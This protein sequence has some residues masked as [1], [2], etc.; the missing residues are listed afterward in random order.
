MYSPESL[1]LAFDLLAQPRVQRP[2]YDGGTAR[3][4]PGLGAWLL[5]TDSHGQPWRICW[6]YNGIGFREL[7][8]V[9]SDRAP[10][11]LPVKELPGAWWPF[12]VRANTFLSERPGHEA[13]DE[14]EDATMPAAAAPSSW[15]CP[16]WCELPNGHGWQ[17]SGHTVVRAHRGTHRF[18][19]GDRHIVLVISVDEHATEHGIRWDAVDVRFAEVETPGPSETA[20]IHALLPQL[21]TLL[22]VA[23]LPLPPR[24]RLVGDLRVVDVPAALSTPAGRA[25]NRA[26]AAKLSRHRSTGNGAEEVA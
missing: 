21:G 15:V 11:M 7:T 3:T 6:Q 16:L 24:I 18:R 13:T 19:F 2:C 26:C 5:V 22:R 17:R 23:E 10:R 1:W 25:T 4:V 20:F 9:P 12:T 8:A 14:P